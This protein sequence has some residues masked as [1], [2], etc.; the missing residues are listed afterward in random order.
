MAEPPKP[1]PELEPSELPPAVAPSPEREPPELPPA[2]DS[3]PPFGGAESIDLNEPF[4]FKQ[5][6]DFSGRNE[7]LTIIPEIDRAG[8]PAGTPP[9]RG[10]SAGVPEPPPAP[11][12]ALLDR[13]RRR[14]GIPFSARIAFNSD[15][16]SGSSTQRA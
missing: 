2:L 13:R 7:P 1:P 8:D 14:K 16:R 12:P 11:S 3:D 4:P 10:L 6:P 9:R 5:P 15:Q